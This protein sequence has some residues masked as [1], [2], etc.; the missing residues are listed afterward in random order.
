MNECSGIVGHLLKFRHNEISFEFTHNE[1]G[2]CGNVFH[3][4]RQQC[5]NNTRIYF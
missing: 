5:R 2:F 4:E 3:T 1:K